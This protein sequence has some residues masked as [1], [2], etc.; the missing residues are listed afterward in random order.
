MWVHNMLWTQQR[1]GF[2]Q[3]SNR[4]SP[5][6]SLSV[7]LGITNDEKHA[8][9]YYVKKVKFNLISNNCSSR[10]LVTNHFPLIKAQRQLLSLFFP[11]FYWSS[12]WNFHLFLTHWWVPKAAAPI[13]ALLLRAQLSF[14]LVWFCFV[15]ECLCLTSYMLSHTWWSSV[16]LIKST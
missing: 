7:H 2:H 6:E 13:D 15:K 14:G 9:F 1:I 5:Y 12:W 11:P 4:S 10:A 3:D 16:S 8:S